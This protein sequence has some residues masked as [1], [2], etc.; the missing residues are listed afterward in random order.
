MAAPKKRRAKC[1]SVALRSTK[2]TPSS[3][4]SPSIW[5]NIGACEASKKSRRYTFP[6]TRTR[7][8]RLVALQGPDLDGRCMRAQQRS[9]LEVQR[10]VH[11]EGGVI[12]REVE[13]REVVPL[14]LGLRPEG[15]REAKL[16]EDVGDLVDDERDRVA[17]TRPHGAGGHRQVLGWLRRSPRRKRHSS[18]LEQGV[19]GRLG[20][21]GALARLAAIVWR[22]G[23]Q[24]LHELLQATVRSPEEVDALCLQL[25]RRRRRGNPTPRLRAKL[26]D[27]REK[28]V[29]RHRG[30]LLVHSCA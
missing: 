4:A 20:V 5:A 22:Q 16:A 21:V 18:L 7:T 28:F 14:G 10:V 6:G 9:A 13:R 29:S 26:G 11:V 3:T 12:S 25:V 27:T 19:D 15:D 23:R 17:P 1:E 30:F 8:G 24:Q 2:L